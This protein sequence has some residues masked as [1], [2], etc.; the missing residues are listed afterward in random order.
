ML[1]ARYAAMLAMEY[2]FVIESVGIG[3]AFKSFA[4]LGDII[5]HKLVAPVTACVFCDAL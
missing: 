4:K 2:A 3:D 5:L 1:V